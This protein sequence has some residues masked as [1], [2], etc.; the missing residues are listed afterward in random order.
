MDVNGNK[1]PSPEVSDHETDSTE[2][3]KYNL[4]I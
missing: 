2:V 4:I 3:N 1:I